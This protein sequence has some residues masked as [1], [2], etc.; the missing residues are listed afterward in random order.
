MLVAACISK[1][2][3]GRSRYTSLRASEVLHIQA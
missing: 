3:I 2:G 1:L